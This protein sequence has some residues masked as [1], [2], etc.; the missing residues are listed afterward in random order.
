M[1]HR[2]R[3]IKRWRTRRATARAVPR[4]V[5][6]LRDRGVTDVLFFLGFH[7]EP[8]LWHVTATDA[9]KA[10]V[11]RHEFFRTQADVTVESEETVGRDFGGDWWA[12]MK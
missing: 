6:A 5:A 1:G 8:V 11:A 3:R 12:A 9:Q 2:G 7:G 4:I 10:E